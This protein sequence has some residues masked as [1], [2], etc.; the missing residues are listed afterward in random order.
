M[1]PEYGH[2]ALIIAF[3]LS[4]ILTVIPILGT[5]TGRVIWMNAA[6]P[7][8]S[9]VFI[10]TLVAFIVLVYSFLQDDFTVKY[11][12]S[13]S[14]TLLP[15]FY[16]VTA[17]WGGHEGSVLL[18]ALV[19]AGWTIAVAMF[20]SELPLQVL[21]R[22]LSVMGGISTGFLAFILFTSNPFDRLLPNPVKEGNDLNPLLQDIGMII[23]PPTLYMG[24]VGFS[25]CFA[26]AIAALIGGR[27]DSSWA[28]WSRPWTN[29]AWVFQTLGIML[30]SWWAYYELGWGGWWFWD[31]VENASFMPWLVGTALV[32]SLAVT[33]KRGVFK[34]WTILLAIL[35]FSLSLLGT[36]IV[37]SGVLT[38]V[39]AFATDPARGMFILA[40]LGLVVGGSL[41]LYAFRI[42]EIRSV[43]GFSLFSRESLLLVNNV[44][45]VVAMAGVLFGTLYPLLVDA[46]WG[47]KLSV[48]P[49]YFNIIFAPL[50]MLVAVFLGFGVMMNWKKTRFESLRM[51]IGVPLLTAVIMGLLFPLLANAFH[52][53]TVAAVALGSWVILASLSDLLRK[54]RNSRPM[55]RGLGKLTVSYW[56]MYVAHFGF[57]VCLMGAAINSIESDHRDVRMAFGERQEIG[58][59][60]FELVDVFPRRGP[61]YDAQAGEVKVY[62]DGQ[63]VTT[64]FPE[65]R[66][67][68]SDRGNVMT[69]AG[70]DAGF[71]RDLFVALGDRLDN[72]AWSMRIH[73]Y[74]LVR[75]IWGGAILMALGGALTVFDRRYR[76]KRAQAE[77]ELAKSGVPA[78]T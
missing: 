19:L 20:S 49:P 6:R 34:S 58:G 65:K 42:P 66:H 61:N 64:L 53:G 70:I 68:L 71:S 5:F 62:K 46:I 36:F 3:I 73:H 54:L 17:V 38:S 72:R 48:G 35:A 57:A 27:L 41:L 44:L 59:Y 69:E 47:A 25:V 16:K 9:G 74:P 77:R 4:I 26:F 8:A 63:Q 51:W 39:H 40:F 50:M 23:H 56:G 1:V 13:H 22:V 15:S 12:A 7:L 14:N 30:G 52:W 37:R 60:E 28:R 45:F 24:Y 32:H 11:V 21:A 43:Q 67:Y 2:L 29:M 75:W 78:A 33:E 31:P 18:W 55:W 10:F 76:M